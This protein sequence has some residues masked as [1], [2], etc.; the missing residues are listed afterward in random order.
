MPELCRVF[1]ETCEAYERC[2]IVI[3]ALDECKHQNYRKE[4]VR[5]LTGLPTAKISLFVTSRPHHHDIKQYFE[6]ALR[7][8]VEAS[9]ADIKHYC[10]HMIEVS[11]NIADIMSVS[12]KQQVIETIANKAHGM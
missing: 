7:I 3:D 6:D 5:V 12:L 2:F 11:P 1:R 8:D 4:I 9:E 10:S